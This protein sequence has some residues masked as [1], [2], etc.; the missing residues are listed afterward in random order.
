MVQV[1]SKAQEVV[2]NLPVEQK[3]FHLY[4]YQI[5]YSLAHI[6]SQ[7]K[8]ARKLQN[9]LKALATALSSSEQCFILYPPEEIAQLPINMAEILYNMGQVHAAL[10][11]H[12]TALTSIE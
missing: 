12:N 1:L 11:A 7:N 4:T 10:G 8:R 5:S 3:K 2:S 9:A 6:L